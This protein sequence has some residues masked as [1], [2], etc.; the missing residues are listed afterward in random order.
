ML[1][2][3]ICTCLMFS[4]I[5][6]GCGRK[7]KQESN[8]ETVL[9]RGKLIVGVRAD[10]KPFG[11]IGKDGYNYG[12]DV[13]LGSHL[14]KSILNKYENAVEFVPVTAQNRIAYLN[15]GKVDC[16]IA[17]MSI[18]KNPAK[19]MDFSIPYYQAGQAVLVNKGNP[20]TTLKELNKQRVII[21]FGATSEA[22]VRHAIP[23]S[24]IIGY[25]DY[26]D[27][28]RALKAGKATAIIGDDSVLLGYTYTDKSI[29]L[30][31]G[32]YSEEPYAIAFRKGKE[33]E[34]LREYTNFFLE[35]YARTGKLS[36]LQEKWGI[37]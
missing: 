22:N 24:P 17:T 31:P 18:T 26:D 11:F 16:L 27:A 25:K 14:A 20:A 8:L 32:R 7:D 29:E 4:L 6:C 1:K 21:V 2:K 35:E 15:S 9:K 33:S 34:R 19:L 13:D 5:L 10:A 23:D 3:I 37:K 12:F 28:I 30:L 36:K